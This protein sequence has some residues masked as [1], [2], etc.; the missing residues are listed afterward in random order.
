M[1]ITD[2]THLN[3]D[4]SAWLLIS[5]DTHLNNDV[6][7]IRVAVAAAAVRGVDAPV[8]VPEVVLLADTTLHRLLLL[9]RAHHL[10]PALVSARPLAHRVR[11]VHGVSRALDGCTQAGFKF[12]VA[13]RSQRP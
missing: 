8:P 3:N 12:S 7:A 6:S 1:L 9:L 2:D 11:A 10:L 5:D 13:L 4:V